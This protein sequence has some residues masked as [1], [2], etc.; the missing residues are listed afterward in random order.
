M[1]FLKLKPN[2]LRGSGGL[3]GGILMEGRSRWQNL[4]TMIQMHNSLKGYPHFK[5]MALQESCP[6][7]K[8]LIS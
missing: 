8:R 2:K 4:C 6:F 3:G 5:R 7:S 1:D